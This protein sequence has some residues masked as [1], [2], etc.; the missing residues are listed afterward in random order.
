MQ[1]A[2]LLCSFVCP[3]KVFPSQGAVGTAVSLIKDSVQYL[4]WEM[5]VTDQ[6]K[7]IK[8]NKNHRIVEL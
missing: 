1:H 6:L 3:T 2:G 8:I 4:Q 5:E 7:I